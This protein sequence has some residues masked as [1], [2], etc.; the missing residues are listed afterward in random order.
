ML[1]IAIIAAS[2]LAVL[3]VS[4]YAAIVV[5]LD[6]VSA[7][8]VLL[9]AMLLGTAVVALTPF[10]RAPLRWQ[11][12]FGSALGLGFLSLLALLLG[13]AGFLGRTLWMSI[14]G[15]MFVLGSS[16]GWRVFMI[17]S[18]SIGAGNQHATGRDSWRY[19]WWIAVPFLVLGLLAA[20]H[21]PGLLWSQEGFGYDVLEY[22]LELPREYLANGAI[23]YLPHNVYGNF[24]AATEML[25]MVAMIVHGKVQDV[26]PV[27][28][29]IHLSFGILTVFAAWVA[30]REWSRAAGI[31]AAVAMATTGWLVYLSGLA[32]VENAMLFFGMTATA[33][34][35]RALNNQSETA[36]S[37]GSVIVWMIASGFC[38]GCACGCKYTAFA[39]VLAPLSMGVF[40]FGSGKINQRLRL[41]AVFSFSALIPLVPWLVKNTVWTGNPVFPLANSIFHAAPDG[42]GV[43]ETLAWDRGHTLKSESRCV[44]RRLSL[45]WSHTLADPAQRFG[46][47]LLLGG[48]LGLIGRRRNCLDAALLFMVF[49]EVLVWI[50]ATHLYARF[51][52]VLLIPLSLLLARAV[53]AVSTRRVRW[54]L[55]IVAM[56]ALWNAVFIAKLYADETVGP[57]PAS[58]IY[59]GELRGDEYIGFV[60]HR[61]VAEARVF[62]LGEA[63]AFYF[64]RPV[65]Y[66]VTFNRNPLIEGIVGDNPSEAVSRWLSREGYTHLLVH[67]GELRRLSRTY[68]TVPPL[69]PE[70]LALLPQTLRKAGCHV[71][72]DFP[73]PGAAKSKAE[74]YVTIY[75]VQE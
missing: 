8:M 45:A 31:V 44:S 19:L 28:N 16:G 42:W 7:L 59:D 74:S 73:Y 6:G 25:Y 60:N 58:V 52:V 20:S 68:G 66:C 38:T 17:A 61:L 75:R 12:L 72:R 27:A 71:L 1:P 23:T 56:G 46:P 9:P 70:D 48:F 40:L 55:A 69:S 10:K 18:G 32:Y 4:P 29:M 37:N 13:L 39:F 47:V 2:F 11:I 3:V 26:G 34:F 33:A 65:G 30:G 54:G 43:E 64:K 51:A 35:L 15:G 41:F 21:P 36:D 5:V 57:A 24:P 67:Y 50:F 22:H 14:L 62:L 49:V 53:C 63:R